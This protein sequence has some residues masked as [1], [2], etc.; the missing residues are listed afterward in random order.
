MA[1]VRYAKSPRD[2][3]RDGVSAAELPREDRLGL[4]RSIS[5]VY[6]TDAEV[7]QSVVPKPLEASLG[8]EVCVTFNSVSVPI[9]PDLTIELRSTSFGVRVE[10]DDKPG[11]Y[12]L[13]MPT[14]S[15]E[16]VLR[17]RERFGLPMKLARIDFEI[18]DERVSSRVE[19]LGIAL[20]SASGRRAED[21]GSRATTEHGYCFKAFPGCTLGKGFDQDPQLVRLEWRHDHARVWRL[22]GE[23]A[24]RD[25]AFDPVAD[26]PV[27][28]IVELEYRE[29]TTVFSG[30]VLRPVP[31]EWLLPFLHQRYDDPGIEG[32]EV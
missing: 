25:S 22:E 6:E 31:G 10:Y 8:S 24:L 19:R 30:R 1:R 11:I 29:G 5:C 9:T 27:R 2:L 7:A 28:R 12:P 15:E 13:T 16:A 26:L 20:L 23:L 4:A 14:N 18:G 32:I 3:E 21:L 17:G